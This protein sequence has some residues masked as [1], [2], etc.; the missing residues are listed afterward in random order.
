VALTAAQ[1]I[2]LA[3]QIAKCPG[4]TAQALEFLNSVLQELALS[5]DFD[6]IR[7]SLQ[8]NFSTTASGNGY[9]P[10]SGPNPMPAD[11]VRLQRGGAFYMIDLVPYK[12][13]GVQQEEFDAFVQQPGLAS[14]PYLAYVDVSSNPAGLF[15]WPP[16]SGNF[17]ATVRY[18][19]MQPDITDTSQVP[20]FPN[21]TYLYTRVAGE[22]MR[23]TNDD[24]RKEFLSD[25]PGSG[26]AG[27]LL[28]KYLTM[29]DDPETA[30]KNVVLDR[31]VFKPNI[32]NLR[33]TKQIGW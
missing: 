27:D 33:N 30:P 23:I 9:A 10:G 2:D 21:S 32:A 8:F 26:G 5:Y 14:F 1:I 24:R 31:R 16:A 25:E 17:P 12:L 20:W 11:F 7:K 19:S 3:T 22:L 4:F 18:N 29:K 28:R 15:V 6:V 13:I